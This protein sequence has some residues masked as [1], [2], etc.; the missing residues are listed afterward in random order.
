MQISATSLSDF[1]NND[2]ILTTF[3]KPCLILTEPT[4]GRYQIRQA[5]KTKDN[6]LLAQNFFLQSHLVNLSSTRGRFYQQS[7]YSNLKEI[8]YHDNI[9]SYY[10]SYI[11]SSCIQLQ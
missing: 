5:L 7:D 4:E 1:K 6:D 11:L 9:I 2:I 3:Q 10:K 8:S